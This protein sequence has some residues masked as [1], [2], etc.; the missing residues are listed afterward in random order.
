MDKISE[1]SAH[2]MLL[3]SLKTIQVFIDDPAVIEIEVNGQDNV[4]VERA[5]SASQMRVECCITQTEID[6]AIGILARLEDKDAKAGT[7][8]GL[9]DARLHGMRVAAALCPT[10]LNGSSLCI[11]KHNPVLLSLSD[12]VDFNVISN[13]EKAVLIKIIKDRKNILIAGGT[14]SGKTTFANALIQEFD[15]GD[16]IITIEDIP[17]L[18]IVGCANNVAF[19]S[20]A[21]KGITTRDL[22]RLSLRYRPDRILVGEVR[23][24]EAYDLLDA[25]NT[26]H[27]GTLATIHANTAYD[28]LSRFETL[29]LRGGGDWP[30]RAIC[31]QIARTFDYVMFMR[32]KDGKRQLAQ[33]I[34][35][36]GYDADRSMYETTTIV[37]RL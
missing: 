26:G 5:G 17:E 35:L 13:S 22:V 11:R 18:R 6:T 8:D 37:D 32:R 7:P 12:Y 25:A 21:Q 36:D 2:K 16:R 9:I 14:S 15:P 30:H 33:V 28:A 31:A 29:V 4:W 27:D 19:Q 24:G 34:K 1:L 20:N 10:S 3:A 23:G